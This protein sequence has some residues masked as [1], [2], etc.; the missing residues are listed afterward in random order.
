MATNELILN[1]FLK[2]RF[3]EDDQKNQLL[4]FSAPKK[5]A[6]VQLFEFQREEHP[7]LY[8]LFVDLT[9][10]SLN[11]LDVEEDLSGTD[12]DLLIN[13]SVLLSNDEVP[14]PPLFACYLDEIAADVSDD[15]PDL[16]ANPHLF[17]EEAT[18]FN[19]MIKRRF[20]GLVPNTP[21]AWVTDAEG[22]GISPGYWLRGEFAEI[23]PQL[24][25]GEKPQIELTDRQT[26]VLRQAKILVEPDYLEKRRREW[27]EQISN[28]AA[29]FQREKYTSL[30]QI[31]PFE[32]LEAIREYFRQLQAEGFMQFN[33]KQVNLRF[34][35]HNDALSRYF[36]EQLAGLISRIAGET[37]KPSYVYSARYIEDAVLEAHT[38]RPQCE[39]TMSMQIDYFPSLKA[40][41]PSPWALCVDD[42][43]GEKVAVHLASGDGMI[44][45]GCELVH[46][47]DALFKGHKSTSIFFHFVPEGFEGSLD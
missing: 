9:N 28:A 14:H 30:R 44:Y 20:Y 13:H 27:S 22:T 16:I 23:V 5:Q 45:K 18:D 38:D 34:A 47:R 1:P 41:E 17:Y 3:Y 19:A 26:T 4:A 24:K 12:R 39:F 8:D 10:T 40:D 2:Y 21:V 25:A 37:V 15:A 42:L 29:F 43:R 7:A 35:A 11:F 32:Q 36:H 33:D 6:G 31:L 46:Y